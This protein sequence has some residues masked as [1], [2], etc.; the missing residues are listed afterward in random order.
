MRDLL[1]AVDAQDESK[2][3]ST[4]RAS[5]ESH[6]M[7]FACEKSRLEGRKVAVKL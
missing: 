4:V 6:V 7:G 3:S 2:L 5:V 1:E